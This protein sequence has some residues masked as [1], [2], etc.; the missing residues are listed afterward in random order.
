MLTN[1]IQRVSF[2]LT[3]LLLFISQFSWSQMIQVNDP[4]TPEAIMSPE[5]LVQNVLVDD[6]VNLQWI[7][8]ESNPDFTAADSADKSYGYFTSNGSGFPFDR[9]LI[10]TSGKAFSAGNTPINGTLSDQSD[11]WINEDLDLRQALNITDPN[12]RLQNT[13]SL[14]FGF[15]ALSD[16]VSFNYI[17]ASEEYSG[18]FPCNFSDGFAFL[19]REAGSTAPYRNI[20][21]L[22]DGTTP[23]TV[24]NIHP[25]INDP[26]SG[27]EECPAIN[28]GFFEGYNIGHTNYNGRTEVLTAS[29]DVVAGT[30]YEI[31]LIVADFRDQLYDV[32]VFLEADSFNTGV[33]LGADQFLCGAAANTLLDATLINPS[34][35]YEWFLDGVQI[36]D[37]AVP[38][39][40]YTAPTLVASA[41]GTYRVEVTINES[42]FVCTSQDEILITLNDV[43]VPAMLETLTACEDGT[44]DGV[45]TFDLTQHDDDIIDTLNDAEFQVLYYE[46]MADATAG[47]A[48]T[49]ADFTNYTNTGS[50]NMGT[51]FA[52]LEFIPNPNCFEVVPFDF[53]VVPNPEIRNPSIDPLI[54]CDTDFDG[55]ASF[56]LTTTR[57]GI[58]GGQTGMTV[59]YHTTM[60]R[61]VNGTNAIGLANN[62]TA[63]NRT[64]FVRVEN[65]VTGCF[66]TTSFELIVLPPPAINP[67]PDDLEACDI[68]N[69][70]IET[71]DLTVHDTFILNGLD[72]TTLEQPF[73]YHLS[74]DDALNGV[75]AITNPTNYN[76]NAT[77]Q[78]IYVRVV[79]LGSL[80]PTSASYDLIL[81]P[82]PVAITTPLV[83]E[84]CDDTNGNDTDQ[85]GTFNLIL[86]ENAAGLDIFRGIAGLTAAYYTNEVDAINATSTTLITTPDSYTNEQPATQRIYARVQSVPAC[87]TVVPI[88]LIVNPL[89]VIN[90]VTNFLIC[91]TDDTQDGL[92]TYSPNDQFTA[93]LIDD[94]TGLTISYHAN[95]NDADND[96][97]PLPDPYTNNT[98]TELLFV[99][100]TNTTT[101]CFQTHSFEVDIEVLPRVIHT[102][103]PYELCDDEN[104]DVETFDLTT[105][106]TELL[107]GL[108]P[109]DYTVRYYATQ[110][111]AEN[112]ENELPDEIENTSNPQTVFY[113]TISNNSGCSVIRPLELLL[114]PTPIFS[115]DGPIRLCATDGVITET[116]I[117]DTGFPIDN[118][119]FEWSLDGQIITGETGPSITVDTNGTYAA[120]VTHT[121]YTTNCNY[122]T[123]V[124]VT[125]EEVPPIEAVNVTNFR[126]GTNTV[127][128]I[129]TSGFSDFEVQLEGE[130]DTYDWTTPN[131]ELS[132]TFTRVPGGRYIVRVRDIY[133]CGMVEQ[134]VFILDYPRFFTPNGDGFNER[135]QIQGIIH[136]SEAQIQIFDR[137]GKFITSLNSVSEGWDGTY[138]GR[139]LPSTD[140][141]F[142]V[143]LSDEVFTNHF[144]LKR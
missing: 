105:R 126:G 46:N 61:A 20:A 143:T 48:S 3:I 26:N 25:V 70:M 42:G 31:K 117:I 28:E 129:V 6:C 74:E 101:N 107:N 44:I 95:Q 103:S 23:V 34:A 65:N 14:V 85:L 111:D 84:V 109:S 90:N 128:V 64:I 104:D 47:G 131:E 13:T 78:T 141:W 35:M 7:S 1:Y 122:T 58:L 27:D 45:T 76:T 2:P 53:L 102:L 110:E 116:A 63:P 38:P 115:L 72:P 133:G 67:N 100:V 49:I 140:Y 91:D 114:R 55:E 39:M 123:S 71:F 130:E 32:A 93:Q 50:P 108:N 41:T 15:T 124:E 82:Q 79:D 80:C 87:F 36:T 113:R 75:N 68:D 60:D 19:I 106:V 52:R 21:L 69:N 43:P 11:N 29:T 51:L 96:V 16:F 57:D 33:N 24:T 10:L 17:L 136:R 18:A 62:H 86:V 125:R 9:G 4:M 30:D 120:T 8:D 94:P 137:Y 121:L 5:E 88:D 138:N 66:A 99:R 56:D 54:E 134:E 40:P 12:A 112:E 81:H 118:Y 77:T 83:L 127:Q 132:H 139:P 37:G 59:T 92:F 98:V 119:T 144:S 142:K 22:P 97:D 73:T 89:P 135:W